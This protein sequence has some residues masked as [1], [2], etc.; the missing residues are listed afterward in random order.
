MSTSDSML[1][2]AAIRELVE[3]W[4]FRRDAGEWDAL[5]DTFHPEGDI[6]VSWFAGPFADFV[7]ASRAR[8]GRSFSKHVM[9]GS[10]VTPRGDRAL[11]ETDV[12]LHGRSVVDGVEVTGTTLMRFLDRVERRAGRWRLLSR[13]AIYDHDALA[14]SIP[15]TPFAVPVEEV[16]ALPAGYRFLAWRLRRAGLTVP[17]LLPTPGSDLERSRREADAAWLAGTA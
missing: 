3:A 8:A 17:A 15:G 9:A 10:R 12:T 13:I 4:G 11:A 7:A 6:A 16:A 2:R 5:L 1:D 14:A